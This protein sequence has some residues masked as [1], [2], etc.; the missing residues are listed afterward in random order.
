[1][2]HCQLLYQRAPNQVYTSAPLCWEIKMPWGI[3]SDKA[4]AIHQ[5]DSCVHLRTVMFHQNFLSSICLLCFRKFSCSFFNSLVSCSSCLYILHTVC[6]CQRAN[7]GS[8]KKFDC[9]GWFSWACQF[10][11]VCLEH[12]CTMK[13]ICVDGVHAKWFKF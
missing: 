2:S 7:F 10:L 8:S 5:R 9:V 13:F 3:T 12:A 6:L 1:M 4:I 11:V